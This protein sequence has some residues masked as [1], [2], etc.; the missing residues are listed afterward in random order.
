M[1]GL[2]TLIGYIF[3]VGKGDYFSKMFKKIG[4]CDQTGVISK[5]LFLQKSDVMTS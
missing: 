4:G 3:K 5:L 1:N 2:E